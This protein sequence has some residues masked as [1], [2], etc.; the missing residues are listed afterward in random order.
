MFG[1]ESRAV[2]AELRRMLHRLISR[3]EGGPPAP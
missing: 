1:Y 2:W 3:R